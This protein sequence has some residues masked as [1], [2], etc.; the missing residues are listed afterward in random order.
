MWAA[1]RPA[2]TKGWLGQNAYLD[3]AHRVHARIEDASRTGKDAGLG[4]FPSSGFAV[5]T[6]WLTAAMT[7]Q[8]LLAWLKLLAL[9][10][11][12]ATAEPKTLRAGAAHCGPAGPRR[13]AAP[14]ENPGHLAMERGDHHRVAADHRAPASPLTRRKPSLQ[15]RKETRGARGTPAASPP[16][17]PPS[18]PDAK[19]HARTRPR[20]CPR[21]PPNPVKDQ[22]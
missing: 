18:Y 17:G 9:D 16:A 11:D 4:R 19:I 20:D 7:G 13:A 14:P 5:N 15:P 10:G 6:A 12:L 2:T 8:I 1:N 22:G 3:A 21:Q